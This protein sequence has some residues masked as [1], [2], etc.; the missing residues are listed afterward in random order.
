MSHAII[1]VTGA[2][3][4]P[5]AEAFR[6]RAEALHGDPDLRVVT[7]AGEGKFF[8]LGGDLAWMAAQEDPTAGLLE[9]VAAFHAGIV[10]LITLPV[11]V[12][13]R[14]HGPAAGGGMSL[15][16]GAD[17]A[18]AAE[19]AYFTMAYSGV[20][21]SP[22]GGGS[23]LLPRIVGARRATEIIMSN[24][25]VGATEAAQLGIVS[26][27]VPDD[28][29]DTAVDELV[30]T[31]ASGPTASYGATKRL[32]A[33]AAESTLEEQLAAEAQSIAALAASPTGQEGIAAF[34]AR[35]APAFP[36]P[37]A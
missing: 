35:R 18:I 29:L 11:P 19:S 22:D 15:V 27:V 7:M 34:L 5:W 2:I 16:L 13:A 30:T 31:L 3:D 23:W 37:G 14:V 20:G 33:L 12:V 24:R 36:A 10:A 4:L 8:S 26:R 9:L 25:R 32:L 17:L 6:D 28:E 21:L 1:D